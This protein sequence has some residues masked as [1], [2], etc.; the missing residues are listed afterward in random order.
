[1]LARPDI[2]ERFRSYGAAAGG[3]SPSAL[4]KVI[5]DEVPKWRSTVESARIT[6]Q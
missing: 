1:V 3:S 4:E 6:A 2:Q 5:A